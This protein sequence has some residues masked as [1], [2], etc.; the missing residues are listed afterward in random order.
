[1][2]QDLAGSRLGH[3][4]FDDSEIAESR[5]ACDIRNEMDLFA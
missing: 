3:R 2:D 4:H 5:L 1:M